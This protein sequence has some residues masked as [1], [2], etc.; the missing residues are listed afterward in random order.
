MVHGMR[1][2]V[3]VSRSESVRGKS[4]RYHV[5]LDRHKWLGPVFMGHRTLLGDKIMASLA[6]TAVTPYPTGDIQRV[7][8]PHWKRKSGDLYTRSARWY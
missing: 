1:L 6:K 7:S 2:R 3:E 4:G 5:N 8:G